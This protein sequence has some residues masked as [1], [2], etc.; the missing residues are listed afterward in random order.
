MGITDDEKTQIERAS[1]RVKGLNPDDIDSLSRESIL[2]SLSMAQTALESSPVTLRPLA[3]VVAAQSVSFAHF[4]VEARQCTR[5]E[6]AKA[7]KAHSD[8]CERAP[9]SKRMSFL[10][11]GLRVMLSSP[12]SVSVFLSVCVIKFGDRLFAMIFA[13]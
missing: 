9:T 7:I 11:S 5:D 2:G 6:V 12:M 10:A 4:A 13:Q 1:E 8:A 3:R